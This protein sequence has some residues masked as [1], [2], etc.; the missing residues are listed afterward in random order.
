[1]CCA[2]NI[3]AKSALKNVY[4]PY[5]LTYALHMGVT[6]FNVY[7]APQKYLEMSVQV[8]CAI[9]LLLKNESQSSMHR[10]WGS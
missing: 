8:Y 2:Y 5:K 3:V 7:S 1:V 10:S 4:K 6:S 9:A